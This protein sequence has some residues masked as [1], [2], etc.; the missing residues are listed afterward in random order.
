MF[1]LLALSLILFSMKKS[2]LARTW[3]PVYISGRHSPS[4]LHIR[5][6]CIDGRMKQKHAFFLCP[7]KCSTVRRQLV[8]VEQSYRLLQSAGRPNLLVQ[9]QRW[10]RK[11]HSVRSG[12]HR[13]QARVLQ[14]RTIGGQVTYLQYFSCTLTVRV[15][16]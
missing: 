13:V 1:L 5:H 2:E 15:M 11:G 6:T 16:K 7:S 8:G 3:T 9:G 12:T 10:I 4:F 14:Q